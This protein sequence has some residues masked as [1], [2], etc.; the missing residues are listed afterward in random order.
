[1]VYKARKFFRP[2]LALKVFHHMVEIFFLGAK[3]PQNETLNWRCF[4]AGGCT[5][6]STEIFEYLT[7]FFDFFF[8]ISAR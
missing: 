7:L 3:F 6:H 8:E 5:A 1:M 2:F 4:L